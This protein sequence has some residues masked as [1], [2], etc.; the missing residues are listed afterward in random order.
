V[1]HAATKNIV[2]IDLRHLEDDCCNAYHAFHGRTATAGFRSKTNHQPRRKRIPRDAENR[3]WAGR[4]SR[5]LAQTTRLIGDAIQRPANL[6]RSRA[7][8][9]ALPRSGCA[10]VEP[11]SRYHPA[12]GPP[13]E[14]RSGA[15]HSREKGP[16]RDLRKH[17]VARPRVAEK[18]SIA[19]YPSFCGGGCST[20]ARR[21]CRP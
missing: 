6:A 3:L 20:W 18:N 10:D 5:G 17:H 21:T 9:L 12:A 2:F 13:G 1:T 11:R 4:R 16:A 8:R 14:T 15:A 19:L 7:G